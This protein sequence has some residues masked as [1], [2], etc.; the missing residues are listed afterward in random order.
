[1]NFKSVKS[2]HCALRVTILGKFVCP[3]T[4]FVLINKKNSQKCV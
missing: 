4:V 3:Y 1:M 2:I